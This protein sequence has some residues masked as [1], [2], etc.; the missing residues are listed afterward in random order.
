VLGRNVVVFGVKIDSSEVTPGI[1]RAFMLCFTKL[2]VSIQSG[3]IP[4]EEQVT[5]AKVTFAAPAGTSAFSIALLKSSF[6]AG[7]RSSGLRSQ[8]VV[9]MANATSSFF[10]PW[11][12]VL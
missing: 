3:P 2:R 6:T 10:P 1:P 11:R 4:M 8:A 5:H 12:I 9:L 7:A